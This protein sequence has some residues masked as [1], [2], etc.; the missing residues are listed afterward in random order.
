MIPT[1][2]QTIREQLQT[3]GFTI[4]PR[5]Q[6]GHRIGGPLHY[7]GGLWNISGGYD[8]PRQGSMCSDPNDRYKAGVKICAGSGHGGLLLFEAS[9]SDFVRFK[10]EPLPVDEFVTFAV[11]MFLNALKSA[12][13]VWS[14]RS[15]LQRRM[16][17]D[18][19]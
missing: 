12:P 5:T 7:D 3:A 19:A 18:A 1:P 17:P 4:D 16:Y 2:I 8:Y 13:Q 15:P 10:R 6:C 9:I 14:N 11:A